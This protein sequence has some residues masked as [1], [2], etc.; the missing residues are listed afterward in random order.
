MKCEWDGREFSATK[1]W[2]RF[3]SSKCRDDWN[4]RERLRR[5]LE[6]AEDRRTDRINGHV[7]GHEKID[8]A[9]LGLV[10]KPAA[11]KRRKLDQQHGEQ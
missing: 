10:A 5:Q 11:I 7:N 6:A 3:Y 9:A 4:N 2:Q 8:L 1:P